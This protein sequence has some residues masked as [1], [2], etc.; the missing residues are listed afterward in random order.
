MGFANI[1]FY[2]KILLFLN[3]KQKLSIVYLSLLLLIFINI[4]FYRLSEHGTDRSAMIL[5]I[6]TIIELLYLINLNTNINKNLFLKLLILITLIISLK[7]FY[8]LYV[9]LLLPVIIFFKE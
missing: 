4:F 9:L 8:I 3:L 5:I 6:V 7:T 2:N 1:I